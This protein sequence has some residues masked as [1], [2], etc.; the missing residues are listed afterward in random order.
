VPGFREVRS[1]DE[2]IVEAQIGTEKL[3]HSQLFWL[4]K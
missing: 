4:E 3:I 1:G 2:K